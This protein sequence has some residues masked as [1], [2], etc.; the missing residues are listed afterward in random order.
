MGGKKILSIEDNASNR[1]IVFDFLTS[2]GYEV[3]EA[4][5]GKEGLKKAREEKPRLILMDIQLSEMDGFEVIKAVRQTAGIKEVPII[6]LSSFAMAGDS[7]K[8]FSAGANAYFIKPYS[9]QELMGKI[10][11]LTE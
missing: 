4:V 7:E 2:K 1:R 9:F 3:I 11:E 10:K 5:N 8:G 6:I